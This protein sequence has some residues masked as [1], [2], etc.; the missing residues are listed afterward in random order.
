LLLNFNNWR[1][2]YWRCQYW[3]LIALFDL[4]HELLEISFNQ[5]I[6]ILKH[7][8]FLY[9]RHW[10]L[11]CSLKSSRWCRRFFSQIFN[12]V[13]FF[14]VDGVRFILEIAIVAIV[15][16]TYM[17]VTYLHIAFTRAVIFVSKQLGKMH[18]V[19]WI[20]GTLFVHNLLSFKTFKL[21]VTWLQL[22]VEFRLIRS[23]GV[24]VSRVQS[25][26]VFLKRMRL[27]TKNKIL[28][29]HLI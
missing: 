22:N 6:F 5:C 1:R 24:F 9:K 29:L 12:Q 8:Y 14:V 11:Y 4:V 13:F 28:F 2:S 21:L 17:L 3:Q 27:P 23:V 7:I 18:I 10:I 20:L 25:E 26:G 16:H 19:D 15:V